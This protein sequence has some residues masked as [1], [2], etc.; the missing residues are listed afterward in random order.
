[1]GECKWIKVED[2]VSASDARDCEWM[3]MNKCK[4]L[5]VIASECKEMGDLNEHANKCK[6]MWICVKCKR[7]KVEGNA[8]ASDC[9]EIWVNANVSEFKWIQVNASEC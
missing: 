4:W 2:N 7:I 3:Q 6:E 5:Q 9:K 1:M 8:K